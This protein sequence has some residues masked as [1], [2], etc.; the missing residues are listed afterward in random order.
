LIARLTAGES[1]ALVSDAGT[2]SVSDP[3]QR[4][5]ADASTAGIRIEPVPG[6]SAVLAVLSASGF[7]ADSFLFLGFAPIKRVARSA[8]IS[9]LLASRRTVVFLEALIESE[10]HLVS[11]PDIW[12][13]DRLCWVV[14]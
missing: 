3:G 6:P 10:G 1:V 4:L 11:W 8:W 7:S 12:A 14:S 5:I 9:E 13:K 2:P